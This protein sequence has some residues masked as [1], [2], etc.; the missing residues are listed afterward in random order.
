VLIGAVLAL[1]G[2][3]VCFL[4]LRLW[5]VMLPLWGFVAGFF[6]G[7]IAITSLFGDGFLSTVTGWVVG[8]VVGVVFAGVSYLF[9]YVGALF[10][11]GSVGGLVGS[12]VMQAIGFE[13]DWILFIV[14][15][16][17]GA[18]FIFVALVAALP[19]YIVVINTSVAGATG[20]VTGLLLMLDRIEREELNYG[21]AT[22]LI[23]E[24]WFWVLVLVGV[25]VVGFVFQ[26]NAIQSFRLPSERWSRADPS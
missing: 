22:A 2:A 5:F 17:V 25:A 12:G 4:G 1:F 26:L 18:L 13:S 16:V 15:A 9:W 23:E 3:A 10:V 7:A 24:S 21:A 14:A 8:F 19:V 20:I 6:V 11:A